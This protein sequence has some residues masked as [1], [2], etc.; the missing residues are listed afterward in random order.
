[1]NREEQAERDFV[2]DRDR[3]CVLAKRDRSHVCTK[4]RTPHRSDNRRLLTVEHVKERGKMAM[5]L[6]AKS[7]RHHMVAMCWDGN[8]AV[9]SREVREWLRDYLL[10]VNG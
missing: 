2:L 9:P 5:G 8:V 1:M 7:D 4:L 6:R 10:E 3:E